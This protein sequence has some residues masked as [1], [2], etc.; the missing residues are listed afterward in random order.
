MIFGKGNQRDQDSC[1]NKKNVIQ[2]QRPHMGIRDT[3]TTKNIK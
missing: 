3:H 1:G 2:E